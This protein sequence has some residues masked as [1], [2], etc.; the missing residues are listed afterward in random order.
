MANIGYV[1]SDNSRLLRRA[2]DE[3]VRAIGVTGPQARLLLRLARDGGR[4]QGF[5]ADELDVEPMTLCRMIDRLEESGMVE[6]QRDPN[7]RRA[8]QI[9][10]TAKAQDRVAELRKC[11]D[12][13]M[14]DTLIGLSVV[15]RDHLIH[16]L[17]V[18]GRNLGARRTLAEAV[19]G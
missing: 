19:H 2:F 13:M 16:C 1:L 9:R 5:Y 3:R 14:E 17:D 10:L 6:R 4:N 7:D 15:D 12:G 18:M 8:W 11:V